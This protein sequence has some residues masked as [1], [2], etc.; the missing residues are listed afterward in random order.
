MLEGYL[1]K[2]KPEANHLSKTAVW[3]KLHLNNQLLAF[4]KLCRGTDFRS[5]KGEGKES[6]IFF[7]VNLE[8]R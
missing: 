6:D 7:S 8:I 4:V 1:L 2:R 3:V 5:V